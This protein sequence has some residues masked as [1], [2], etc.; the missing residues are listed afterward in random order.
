MDK[1]TSDTVFV[2][3]GYPEADEFS[4][5]YRERVSRVHRIVTAHGEPQPESGLIGAVIALF[6]GRRR[7]E[8]A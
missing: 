4:N 2:D 6:A 8:S 1:N 3:D 7:P 5:N